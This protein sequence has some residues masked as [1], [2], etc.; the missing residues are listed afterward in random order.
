M[1]TTKRINCFRLHDSARRGYIRSYIT[2]DRSQAASYYRLEWHTSGGTV[3]LTR[4]AAQKDIDFL[5]L[6]ADVKI[7]NWA[8]DE[9]TETV[10]SN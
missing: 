8:Y 9:I 5:G 2:I 3:Y 6:S 1:T 10:A 7:T 4:E